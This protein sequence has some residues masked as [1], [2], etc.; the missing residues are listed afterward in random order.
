MKNKS[1]GTFCTIYGIVLITQSAHMM[2]HFFIIYQYAILKL[3]A[4]NSH[5]LIGQFDLESVH[6]I[7]DFLFTLGFWLIWTKFP[8]EAKNRS[9]FFYKLLLFASILQ[10]YHF[11]EHIIKYYQHLQTGMQGTP[12]ILGNFVDLAWLHFLLNL[13][14]TIVLWSFYI[15]YKFYR[16]CSVESKSF[17]VS[18]QEMMPPAQK[19]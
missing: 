11:F 6:F 19:M 4:D 5:G 17:S 7:Y 12:G 2:E 10:S 13:F 9:K 1:I 3:G 16:T 8:E 14:G 15:G 18:K